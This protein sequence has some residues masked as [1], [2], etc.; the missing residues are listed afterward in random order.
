M[1][2]RSIVQR[3]KS[4]PA[5]LVEPSGCSRFLALFLSFFVGGIV[6]VYLFIL[7]I[8]PYD[9][10]PFSL[11]LERPILSVAQRFTY[12]QIVRSRRFDSLIVGSSTA[13]LIDPQQLNVPFGARFANFSMNAM[14]AWDQLGIARYF[15]RH[16]RPPRF[17]TLPR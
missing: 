9:M 1:L 8:D 2:E 16:A 13:R 17:L 3:L 11:P 6:L 14:T 12:P 5:G 15:L 4:G 10:V 7:L